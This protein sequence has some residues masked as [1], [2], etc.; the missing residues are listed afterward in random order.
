MFRRTLLRAPQRALWLG[1]V[2]LF[3]A[4]AVA[5]C[6]RSQ[7][8]SDES[9]AGPPTVAAGKA[10]AEPAVEPITKP[11][12]TAVP[13][14]SVR[15]ATATATVADVLDETAEPGP[16]EPAQS[17]TFPTATPTASGSGSAL[18]AV[19]RPGL[20]GH[21]ALIP[22][23]TPT[24]VEAT[25]AREPGATRVGWPESGALAASPA[26]SLGRS[27]SAPVVRAVAAKPAPPTPAALPAIPDR[28]VLPALDLDTP[29]VE[30]GWNTQTSRTGALFSEWEVAE[31]AAGWHKNSA[32][33]GQGSNIVFSGHNNILGAVF[34]ELDRLQRGDTA[35]LYTGDQVYEYAIDKVMIVP[36]KHATDDQRRANAQWIAATDEERLTLVSCWPRDDNTHRIIVV[37]H[38]VSVISQSK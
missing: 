1:V 4:L 24:P 38:P 35:L 17:H 36:E 13:A 26:V 32:L 10:A 33:P 16:D 34:R 18:A 3:V 19:V 23:A 20:I 14:R 28:L 6:G 2:L 27:P 11:A 12:T 29:V 31:Y 30:L 5:T 15:F 21:L 25:P 37:A 9:D 22:T 7:P 8:E